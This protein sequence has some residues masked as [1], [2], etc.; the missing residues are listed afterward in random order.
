MKIKLRRGVFETNSSSS[1]A[2]AAINHSIP[3]EKLQE[4]LD[5]YN[6][7]TLEKSYLYYQPVKTPSFLLTTSD[8]LVRHYIDLM[9]G[10]IGLLKR[11]NKEGWSYITSDNMRYMLLYRGFPINEHYAGIKADIKNELAEIGIET[12]SSFPLQGSPILG[13][14]REEHWPALQEKIRGEKIPKKYIAIIKFGSPLYH[15]L[16]LGEKTPEYNLPYISPAKNEKVLYFI[17]H[18][19]LGAEEI[20]EYLGIEEYVHLI[21]G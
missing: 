11:V 14:A 19:D 21:V 18:R 20:L 7:K 12:F 10:L 1:H 6:T 17:G 15:L 5:T 13:I 16:D 9:T 4:I 3:E 8:L 2:F